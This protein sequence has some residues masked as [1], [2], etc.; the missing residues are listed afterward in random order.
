MTQDKHSPIKHQGREGMN[1]L[2]IILPMVEEIVE[3]YKKREHILNNLADSFT[4]HEDVSVSAR[5]YE[6][7]L[8]ID[9]ELFFTVMESIKKIQ[10]SLG[11]R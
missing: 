11:D 1:N 7:S 5:H 8:D 6:R 2:E 9:S 4:N 10:E 3:V